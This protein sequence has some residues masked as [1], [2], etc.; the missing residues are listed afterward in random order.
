[1]E[2]SLP[3][4]PPVEIPHRGGQESNLTAWLV[5]PATVKYFGNSWK[6][7]ASVLAAVITGSSLADVAN[8]HG[9]SAEAAY[10]YARRAKALF[11]TLATKS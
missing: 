9:V 7:K 11:P 4:P 6:L 2:S 1:M 5:H 8:E 10:K 3:T